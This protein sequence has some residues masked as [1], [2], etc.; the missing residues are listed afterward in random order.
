MTLP[1]EWIEEHEIKEGDRILVK[2]NGHIEVR[3]KSDENLEL[4][5]KEIM[6]IR[7]H[8]SHMQVSPSATD[9]NNAA[10]ESG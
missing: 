1:K 7:N 10:A 9:L 8:L 4:M 5:N 6:E 3:V 2:A